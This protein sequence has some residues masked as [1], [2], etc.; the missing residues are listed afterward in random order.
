MQSPSP[1]AVDLSNIVRKSLATN[2]VKKTE[3]GCEIVDAFPIE[4]RII[5]HMKKILIAIVILAVLAAT[6]YFVFGY[7]KTEQSSQTATR[8]ERL[9]VNRANGHLAEGTV[10]T[11]FLS[12]S[13]K[14]SGA[15][16]SAVSAA[17]PQN[18]RS[19]GPE[20]T[21]PEYPRPHLPGLQWPPHRRCGS[22]SRRG[23]GPGAIGS[24]HR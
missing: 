22:G 2:S 9:P 18:G 10:R 20:E 16:I 3:V 6:G 5:T 23:P 8:K 13:L 24:R 4:E 11:L 15:V 12:S 21:V 17:I 14:T 1:L 7:G 19:V